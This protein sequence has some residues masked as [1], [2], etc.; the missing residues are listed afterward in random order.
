MK[1]ILMIMIAFFTAISFAQTKPEK[2]YELIQNKKAS[3]ATFEDVNLFSVVDNRNAKIQVPKELKNYTIFSMQKNKLNSFHS[4]PANTMSLEIP[5]KGAPLTLELARVQIT[6]D[7]F[8]VVAMPSGKE[9]IPDR[10]I[11]HYRGVVKGQQNSVVAVSFYQDEMAGIVSVKGVSGNIVIGAL[12][13]SNK[14]IAYSDTDISHLFDFSCEVRDYANFKEKNKKQLNDNFSNEANAI[15]KCPKVFFDIATDIVSDKGGVQGASDYIQA[16]F[17]QVAVIY[18]GEQITI[19]L[20]GMKAWESNQPFSDIDSYANYRRSNTFDGDLGHF[21]NYASGGANGVAMSLDGLCSTT[22]YA[23][24]SIKKTFENV[25]TFSETIMVVTHELGHNLGSPHTQACAWNGNNTPID[26]CVAPEGNCTRPPKPAAGS[27][28]GTIMS[29]CALTDVGTNFANGF[30]QQPGDKIRSYISA[31]SCVTT[32]GGCSTGD[33]VTVTFSNTT[34]CSLEY[35]TN[36]TSQF[37]VAAGQTRETSTIVG[38]SWEAKKADATVKDTFTI[39]CGTT[40]YTS[41]GNCAATPTCNDGI[42]NGDET[43]VDCGGSCDPCTNVTYCSSNGQSVADEY[44]GKVALGS[45]SNTTTGSSG[46]YGDYTSLSTTLSKGVSNTIT[47]TPAW[48]ST[49]Y[50]E[51]Y[52]VWIDYNGDGDFADSGEQVFSKAASRDT[53]V[54]GS[55]TVPASATNGNT[56]MR[57]S[58]KYNGIPTPCESF[59]YGEV[60]DYTV[61]I[62]GGGTDPTCNDGIQNGDE[63]GIDCGGSCEPCQTNVT[64]CSATGNGGPEGISNVTFA[65]INKSSTRSASG[66]EDHTSS[67]ANVSVGTNHNLKVTIIG[68][69]GGATDEIY[70]WVDWNQ[71]GDFADAGENYTVAKTSNLEGNVSISVPQTAKAGATRMRVL[72]SYYDNENNPCDTGTNDVRYGEYEDYTVNVAASKSYLANNTR[73]LFTVTKNPIFDKQLSL[74][75]NST[76]SSM[77]NVQLYD[78]RGKKIATYTVQKGGDTMVLPLSAKIPTGLYLVKCQIGDKSGVERVVVEK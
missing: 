8:K 35:F 9:V 58:M 39:A 54:S 44:I 22:G 66:Y 41:S 14:M 25:P 55:F 12:E 60:E 67:S 62:T 52:S 70:A 30:G 6:T 64:Y 50:D 27:N 7:N 73:S 65:G 45:I 10:Q 53:S 48:S 72:V 57:V 68:Y 78:V 56:R 51:G 21:V 26:G 71:D 23:R 2:P 29:Y 16:M 13:N 28:V 37:T 33:Q 61:T 40:T 32:C 5:Q 76:E 18:A 42:Q 20:S 34:D 1:N 4:K 75:F 74:R 19:K 77:I 63:T 59:S 47:I 36:N 24:S 69:Q 46:G 11:L 31:A 17:N 15:D 49:T 3:G 43:G 38:A